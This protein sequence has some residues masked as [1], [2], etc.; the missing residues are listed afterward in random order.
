MLGGQAATLAELS[1]A[2]FAVPP[3]IMVTAGALDEPDLD[4]QLHRA[5]AVVTDG[6]LAAHYAQGSA[7]PASGWR[8]IWRQDEDGNQGQESDRVRDDSATADGDED[9]NVNADVVATIGECEH[10]LPYPPGVGRN[11][12]F[13]GVE[14][15]AKE[16]LRDNPD[17]LARLLG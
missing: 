12:V 1:A 13:A 16:A 8:R 5:A 3:G 17:L 10:R 7:R 9:G 15:F 4:G 6:T 2:G 11:D 14:G